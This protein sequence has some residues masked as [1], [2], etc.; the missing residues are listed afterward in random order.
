MNIAGLKSNYTFSYAAL[1]L[2]SEEKEIIALLLSYGITPTGDK[3][4]D[5]AKL[6]EI[7]HQKAIQEA[8]VSSNK[9]HTVS[10]SE[11]ENIQE[12]KNENNAIMKNGSDIIANYNKAFIK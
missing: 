12:K 4:K 6:H 7:E 8:V 5:R 2:D 1:G 9:F 11:Q 10:K 3:S